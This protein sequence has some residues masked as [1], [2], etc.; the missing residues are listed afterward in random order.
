MKLKFY[1]RLGGENIQVAANYLLNKWFHGHMFSLVF[2]F[3]IAAAFL[4]QSM[5]GII[6]PAI[7]N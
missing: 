4:V 6:N 7:F 5:N 2:S 1:Y 3:V